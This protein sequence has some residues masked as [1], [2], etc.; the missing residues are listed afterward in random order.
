MEKSRHLYRTLID[1]VNVH[2]MA[3]WLPQQ[4][5]V[6]QEDLLSLYFVVIL[7]RRVNIL[8]PNHVFHDLMVMGSRNL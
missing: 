3:V 5:K 7:L 4:Q 2:A 6:R 1:L 8:T